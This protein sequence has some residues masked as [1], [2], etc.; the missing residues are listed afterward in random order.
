[1][2]TSIT[3]MPFPTVTVCNMNQARKSSIAKF[4]TDSVEYSMIESLC[5]RSS[6]VTVNSS[7]PGKW[8]HFRKL[9]LDVIYFYSPFTFGI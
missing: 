3:E 1:M 8:I 5:S 2:S 7:K 4:A 6:D 9:L